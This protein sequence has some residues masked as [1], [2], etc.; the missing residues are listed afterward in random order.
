MQLDDTILRSA[1][2]VVVEEEEVVGQGARLLLTLRAS[3]RAGMQGVVAGGGKT[4]MRGE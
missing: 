2:G 3:L 1:K 4:G